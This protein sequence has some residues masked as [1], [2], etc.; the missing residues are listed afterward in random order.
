MTEMTDSLLFSSPQLSWLNNKGKDSDIALASRIRL[1]RNLKNIPFPNR[2]TLA[3][4][5]QVK[6]L[7]LSLIPAIETAIDTHLNCIAVDK[8]TQLE[9][10]V[11]IEKFLISDKLVKNPEN[12]L[13]IVSDDL[14]IAIMVNEDDHLRIQ[15]MASGV[16]L[17]TL[18]TKAF[19]ID[20]AIESY[21]NIAFD[22]KMG[23]LTSCPTNL[24]TGLRASILLHLPALVM[25]QQISKIINIS[26][27]LGLAV[28]PLFG[29]D[30]LG[31]IFQISNQL[32]LGFK[33]EELIENLYT[34]VQEIVNHER[35]ARKALLS[36]S[37]DKLENRV[38][39]SFGILKYAHS[40]S[41]DEMLNLVSKVR[42][43]VDMGIVDE[44]KAEILNLLLIAGQRYYLQN[45][46]QNE[47]MS[48]QEIDKQRSYVIRQIFS[49]LGDNPV[50]TNDEL[51]EESF[52]N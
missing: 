3:N 25:T 21:L 2:A 30:S 1:A 18:L 14:S 51:G 42:L 50:D 10:N 39:R 40:I 15:C 26:P 49:Q 6:D 7:I 12:R 8:L 31:N 44:T 27:Q 47:N 33:E 17:K 24:G 22:E 28:R 48:P 37:R 20:D 19:A 46:R 29:E 23:Y 4:L 38:W 52:T 34:T 9:Q 45:L 36:Y 5:A 16:E 32:T 43:G 41:E 11:L 13:L 35:E